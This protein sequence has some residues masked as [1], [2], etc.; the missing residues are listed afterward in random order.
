MHL[1]SSLWKGRKRQVE[2]ACEEMHLLVISHLDKLI[3]PSY[4]MY[5]MTVMSMAC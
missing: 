5:R 1:R 3:Q 4:Y 2:I